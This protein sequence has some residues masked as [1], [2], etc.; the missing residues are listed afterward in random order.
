MAKKAGKRKTPNAPAA[1]PTEPAGS[2]LCAPASQRAKEIRE[3]KGQ[4]SNPAVARRLH[5]LKEK[6][7]VVRR[8]LK[9]AVTL[10]EEAA[11]GRVSRAAAMRCVFLSPSLRQRHS[12]PAVRDALTAHSLPKSD[13]SCLAWFVANPQYIATRYL[14]LQLPGLVNTAFGFNSGILMFKT[15][16]GRDQALRRGFVETAD[17]KY[18]MKA[19][20]PHADLKLVLARNPK[21]QNSYHVELKASVTAV[22]A[23]ALFTRFPDAEVVE[24]ALDR[25]PESHWTPWPVICGATVRFASAE[26]CQRAVAVGLY[27]VEGEHV[28]VRPFR[29]WADRNEE[30]PKPGVTPAISPRKSPS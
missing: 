1:K 11:E 18:R 22:A 20:R 21:F 10:Q 16:F 17:G 27:N 9:A 8:R 15:P 25:Q 29:R 14:Q 30:I 3:L 24:W 26:A 28:R 2:A 12:D 7:R 13:H 6:E 4:S 23:D 19:F 5:R